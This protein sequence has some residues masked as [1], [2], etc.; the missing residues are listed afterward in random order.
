[1][2]QKELLEEKFMRED[3]ERELEKYQRQHVDKDAFG[4]KDFNRFHE[5]TDSHFGSNNDTWVK[6]IYK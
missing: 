3:R 1:M 4:Q 5:S 6:V 2:L